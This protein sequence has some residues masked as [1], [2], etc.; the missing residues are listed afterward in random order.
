MP[1]HSNQGFVALSS[2]ETQSSPP[3]RPHKANGQAGKRTLSDTDSDSE[4]NTD[5]YGDLP[6]TQG[7]YWWDG[8]RNRPKDKSSEAHAPVVK[9]C[10]NIILAR[11]FSGDGAGGKMCTVWPDHFDAMFQNMIKET[12]QSIIRRHK[13][14]DLDKTSQVA[15]QARNFEARIVSQ[16]YLDSR[17]MIDS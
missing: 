16:Y 3:A 10:K 6:G 11:T 15:S 14:Y 4:V 17:A 5:R 2:R 12:W 13:K 1:S 8:T 7:L 9:L